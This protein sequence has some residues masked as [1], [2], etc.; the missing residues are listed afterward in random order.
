M[1]TSDI[2]KKHIND[3]GTTGISTAQVEALVIAA[4]WVLSPLGLFPTGYMGESLVA[5][6]GAN[7]TRSA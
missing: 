3:I 2:Y 1:H 5:A 6:C 7:S 4:S